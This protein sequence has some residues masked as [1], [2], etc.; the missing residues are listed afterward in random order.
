MNFSE[1]QSELLAW[2]RGAPRRTV[3]IQY[4][5]KGTPRKRATL[6]EYPHGYSEPPIIAGTVLSS[7]V[8]P[9]IEEWI[10]R[11][12]GSSSRLDGPISARFYRTVD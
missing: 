12:C 11:Y 7:V 1:E 4:T 3:N 9:M 6:V 5:A 2:L 10:L 8:L